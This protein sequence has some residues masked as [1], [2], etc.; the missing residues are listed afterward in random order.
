MSW[1]D[2]LNPNCSELLAEALERQNER[3]RREELCGRF[4]EELYDAVEAIAI[5]VLQRRERDEGS[6]DVR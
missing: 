6:R 5:D 2:V 4:G 3:K 1:K